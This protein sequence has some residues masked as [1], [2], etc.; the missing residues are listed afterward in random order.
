MSWSAITDNFEEPSRMHKSISDLVPNFETLMWLL[1][2]NRTD[3][4]IDLKIR[5]LPYVNGSLYANILH[6]KQLGFSTLD[7]LTLCC[8]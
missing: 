8:Y 7:L 2:V 6:L 5:P 1:V 4:F 3:I